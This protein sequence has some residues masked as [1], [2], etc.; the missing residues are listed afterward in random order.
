MRKIFIEI[1]KL[2]QYALGDESNKKLRLRLKAGLK[3][4]QSKSKGMIA[5]L[6]LSGE[7]KC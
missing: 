5:D 1:K 7:N 4:N 3:L 2:I 6:P